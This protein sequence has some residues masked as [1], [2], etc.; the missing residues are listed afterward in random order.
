[1]HI[2]SP[3]QGPG[4]VDAD[5]T[6]NLQQNVT[7]TRTSYGGV[8]L[9]PIEANQDVTCRGRG[10][11]G[12]RSTSTMQLTYHAPAPSLCNVTQPLA[13]LCR[14]HMLETTRPEM[15]DV[16]TAPWFSPS[17]RTDRESSHPKALPALNLLA[18]RT[19]CLNLAP[20]SCLKKRF[21]GSYIL[22]RSGVLGTSS[23]SRSGSTAA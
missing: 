5:Y 9:G 20:A 13:E 8:E 12:S 21:R 11:A 7:C 10:L 19:C 2:E 22:R 14:T 6:M 16:P 4:Y 15:N 1:M 23:S 3:S 17:D 18:A